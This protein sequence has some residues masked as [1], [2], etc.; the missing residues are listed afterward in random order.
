MKMKKDIAA[1]G[2]FQVVVRLHLLVLI[3]AGVG[4]VPS[5]AAEP[6]KPANGGLSAKRPEPTPAV[7]VLDLPEDCFLQGQLVP[8][9]AGNAPLTTLR[10]RS[11]LFAEPLEFRFGEVERIRF[12]APP[13]QPLAA[14]VWRVD[15]R[16]GDFGIGTLE[17]I[18]AEHI[19][20]GAVGAGPAPLRIR[21][22]EVERLARTTAETKVFVPGLL[23]G[24]NCSRGG[25]REE[26]GRIVCEQAGTV[27]YRDVAAPLRACFEIVVAWDNRPE[28]ELFFASGPAAAKPAGRDGAAEKPEHYRIEALGGELI[29]VREG[30]TAAFEPVGA[31]G[32][33][34]GSL[35]MRVFIDQE[36]GRMAVL[37]ADA[38]AADRP[39]FD[40]TVAPGKAGRQSGLT[41]K[42]RRGGVRID[43]L[44]VTPWTDEE[45]K[46]KSAGDLGGPNAV[47]ES[48]DRTSGMFTAREG[49]D[50]KQVAAADVNAVEFP[51][52]A[53][54]VA[55]PP[56]A[57][58]TVLHGGTRL[59][60]RIVEVTDDVLR[61]DC[62]S[63][64][65]PVACD[66]RQLALLEPVARATAPV[67]GRLGLL[68]G[69]SGRMSGRLV[70]MAG[71][72]K[73]IAWHPRGGV[74][75][76]AIGRA[77]PLRI[78]YARKA[79]ADSSAPTAKPVDAGSPATL[80]L[81][82]GES[83]LC[84]V[85]SANREGLR[86]KTDLEADLHVPAIAIRAVELLPS[87]AGS[88]PKD[89]F[90]R[91]LTL[92]RSQQADPPTHMLRLPSGDYLRGKLIS[93]DEATARI[94]VV[95]TLKEFPRSEVARL[96]WLSMEGDDSELRAAQAVLQAGDQPGVPSRATMI[97]GRRISLIAERLDGDRLVGRNG[98][99]GTTSVDL[100][101]VD[102]LDL[103]PAALE[104][105][106]DAVPYSQWKLKP[107]AVPRA[108]KDS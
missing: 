68:E 26:A 77:E 41:L 106:Q 49:D 18:D 43:S 55:P 7:S 104:Q 10:W 32:D 63:V 1:S 103:G 69:S 15:L 9:P 20:L 95:G 24:W 58:Q 16:G 82:T 33:A 29:V 92:P 96:I 100:E 97:D 108:L 65:D 88:L 38:A 62:P 19:V 93:L 61:L 91:L 102:R 12:H 31:V 80:Y 53:A 74:E 81:K 60:G 8:M 76:V 35:R 13:S 98:V 47:L 57:V 51:T 52:A 83:I 50:V 66:R 79:S 6:A 30:A 86:I 5:A 23:A 48:F 42:L 87:S 78:S 64:A 44:R 22:T 72:T 40:A 99:F 3:V 85:L 37:S 70:N 84:S 11:P 90:A 46:V 36:R 21:R 56:A 25:V 89:K 73:G 59:T 101:R 45:P 28:F 75:P 4:A 71:N 39:L 105:P 34:D 17:S 54:T 14:D 94:E 27:A 107:A 67:K 2:V